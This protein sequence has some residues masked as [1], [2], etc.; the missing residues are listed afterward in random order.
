MVPPRL[1]AQDVELAPGDGGGGADA[2]SLHG[3]PALPLAHRGVEGVDAVHALEAVEAAG[4][5]DP[6]AERADRARRPGRGHGREDLPPTHAGVEA[7]HGSQDLPVATLAAQD[8]EQAQERHGGAAAPRR[9]HL[10]QPL[11]AASRGVQALGR[12]PHVFHDAAAEDVEHATE[13][14][15]GAARPRRGHVLERPPGAR[16][17]VEALRRLELAVLPP[18]AVGVPQRGLLVLAAQHVQRAR[19][20]GGRAEPPRRGH[21]G[22]GLPSVLPRVEAA[23]GVQD[24]AEDGRAP[25]NVDVGHRP[26]VERGEGLPHG[27]AVLA[28]GGAVVEDGGDA[29]G[30]PYHQS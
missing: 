27:Q 18:S 12:G 11:P 7:L 3:L 29:G 14:R 4:D 21:G 8:V 30:L 24:P 26:R 19:D 9:R 16:E 13:R 25:A 1:A 10:R 17:G 6:A 28:G 23:D 2:P 22:H 20:R 15:G 5:E